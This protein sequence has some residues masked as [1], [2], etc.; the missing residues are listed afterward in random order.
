MLNGKKKKQYLLL[1]RLNS[2]QGCIGYN[3]TSEIQTLG[4]S[5]IELKLWHL[6][7]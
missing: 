2:D 5:L 1:C 7:K 4:T 3:L 6:N